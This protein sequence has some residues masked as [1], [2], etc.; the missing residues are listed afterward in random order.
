MVKPGPKPKN[1]NQTKVYLHPKNKEYLL[2][3]GNMSEY[4]NKLIAEDMAKRLPQTNEN[5]S[6]VYPIRA[7]G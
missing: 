5:G 1:R 4:L 7:E 2:S 3:K 6:T